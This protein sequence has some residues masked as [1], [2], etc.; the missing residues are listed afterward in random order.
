MN[1]VLVVSKA[2]TTHEGETIRYKMVNVWCPGCDRHHTFNVAMTRT[3]K[4]FQPL[5][6]WDGD[7]KS[8]TFEGSMLTDGPSGR[9]HSLLRD[10]EW[11]FL[12]DS[13]HALAGKKAKMVPVPDWL[14]PES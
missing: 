9:C 3:P 1:P 7:E 11:E 2:E 8:P 12:Q 10:G 13:D 5:W 4:T 6:G 14:M